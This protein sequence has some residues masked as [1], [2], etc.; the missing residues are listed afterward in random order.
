MTRFITNTGRKNF[1]FKPISNSEMLLAK[2][3]F[4]QRTQGNLSLRRNWLTVYGLILASLG[5]G[6]ILLGALTAMQ[7]YQ[8]VLYPNAIFASRTVSYANVPFHLYQTERYQTSDPVLQVCH[9]YQQQTDLQ[10]EPVAG[11]H[12]SARSPYQA[13]LKSQ[14]SV[15]VFESGQGSEIHVSRFITFSSLD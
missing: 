3:Q 13:M 4:S 7:D 1:A 5:L 9:W 10:R 8:G 6:W 14:V 2:K 12:L 15:S 11:C